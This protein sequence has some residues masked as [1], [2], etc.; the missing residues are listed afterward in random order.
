MRLY[1]CKECENMV[2]TDENG[3]CEKCGAKVAYRPKTN[4][5]KLKENIRRV[6]KDKKDWYND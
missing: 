2:K 3:N 6:I 5:F 4:T 1:F